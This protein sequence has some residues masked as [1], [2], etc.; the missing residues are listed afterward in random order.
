VTRPVALYACH[1]GL[2]TL[3]QREF[4][5]HARCAGEV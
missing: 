2:I 5:A 4:G 3:L 1:N